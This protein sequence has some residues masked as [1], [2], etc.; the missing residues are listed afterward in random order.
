MKPKGPR[1]REP[2]SPP[3]ETMWSSWPCPT[4]RASRAVGRCTEQA[5]FF[6]W[7]KKVDT[8][9]SETRSNGECETQHIMYRRGRLEPSSRH[10]TPARGRGCVMLQGDWLD[11]V[12][13]PY[14]YGT[15]NQEPRP[16]PRSQTLCAQWL[17]PARRTSPARTE[18]GPEGLARLTR[19]PEIGFFTFNSLASQRETGPPTERTAAANSLSD[20]VPYCLGNPGTHSPV[21]TPFVFPLPTHL[22]APVRPWTARTLR[23]ACGARVLMATVQRNANGVYWTAARPASSTT[24][25]TV[26][27]TSTSTSTKGAMPRQTP[28]AAACPA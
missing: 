21:I 7:K 23:L 25:T 10:D 2:S 24:T 3:A 8:E 13:L 1:E 17:S 9:V 5:P 6:L 27:W 28:R 15:A 12:G 14:G 19:L 22:G 11:W 26:I 16:C 18:G 4:I 20:G